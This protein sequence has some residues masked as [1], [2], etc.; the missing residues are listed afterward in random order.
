M[1]KC[2]P[3]FSGSTNEHSRPTCCEENLRRD[4]QILKF[5][6]AASRY[7]FSG[8]FLMDDVARGSVKGRSTGLR[9]NTK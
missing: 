7:G 8:A 1:C 9:A 6:L 2:L 4:K 5:R 3:D